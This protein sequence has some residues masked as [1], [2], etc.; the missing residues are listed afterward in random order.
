MNSKNV[1]IKL[2]GKSHSYDVKVGSDLLKDCG[3]WAKE[4]LSKNTTKIAII[5]NE[6]VFGLYG[7][8]VEQSL[9]DKG[10]EIFVWLMQD[11]EEF[12]NFDSFQ[13]A[14]GF[15][16]ENKLSRTDAVIALG[17][18]VV[19]DL[20]GF[21]AAT[22]LRGI[23]FLQ[24][25][26]T[27]LSMI[28]S[29]VGGKTAINTA[30]GKNLVGSFYQPNGVLV[31]VETLKTLEH[32]ELV[33]GFCEAIKQGAIG[34]MELLTETANF[35]EKYSLEELPSYYYDEKF[36]HLLVTL[37]ASQIG[38]KAEIVM[39]DEQEA[40]G[41]SDAKSRKIL[42]FGHTVAHALEKITDYK[43]FKHGEA[44]GYGILAAGEISKKLDICDSNSINLLKDVVRSVGV[45]PD[46]N[47]ISID[48]LLE[49]FV[50]D[51]KLIGNSLQWILLEDIGKPKIISSQ[52]IPP[53]IIVE[54][55]QKILHS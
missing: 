19:G 31:D 45:L 36:R 28:D 52:I 25:P 15:F 50:F 2:I 35:L 51:K 43:Y 11:G 6:K 38:F 49:L 34:G 1:S 47:N 9:V 26:T 18:G 29:S 17:G 42:N 10:F 8:Q 40:T 53:N 5:S 32:R 4:H 41:R 37:L 23:S 27:V 48:E 16:G 55:L 7:E 3:V 21:A 22:Y 30:F 33:A 46:T 54:S 44:V 13:E 24:I 39:Q 12:K 20:A 14:L